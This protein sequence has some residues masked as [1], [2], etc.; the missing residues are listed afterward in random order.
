MA[1]GE[2]RP[3]AHPLVPSI[4]MRDS[5]AILTE[6]RNFQFWDRLMRARPGG[7]AK[8]RVLG[9]RGV[10]TRYRLDRTT[11]KVYALPYDDGYRPEPP[12]PLG[13]P[14]NPANG[15]LNALVNG[16]VDNTGKLLPKGTPVSPGMAWELDTVP[17]WARTE[18]G[19]PLSQESWDTLRRELR[20]DMAKAMANARPVERTEKSWN[21]LDK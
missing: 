18:E 11:G 14:G 10:Q 16:A 20:E 17:P 8:H 9:S 4:S 13:A 15:F 5:N 2:K 12:I 3:V 21:G 1:H 7:N 6:Y 19:K